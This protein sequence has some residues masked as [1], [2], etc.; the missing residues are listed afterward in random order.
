MRY[1]IKV[2]AEGMEAHNHF[3]SEEE[4]CEALFDLM[5]ETEASGEL[6]AF[7]DDIKLEPIKNEIF[8]MVYDGNE[9][10]MPTSAGGTWQAFDDYLN[11]EL[12]IVVDLE[13]NEN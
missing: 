7:S 1:T 8:V 5:V 10:L 4:V 3:V 6:M 2:I 11:E 9:L 13:N 12:E